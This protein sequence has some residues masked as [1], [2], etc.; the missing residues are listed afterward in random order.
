MPHIIAKIS[1]FVKDGCVYLL[2]DYNKVQMNLQ[3]KKQKGFI[4][5][6]IMIVLALAAFIWLVYSRVSQS[7]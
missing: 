2:E 7:N 1:L 4:P 6:I 3:N 5:M